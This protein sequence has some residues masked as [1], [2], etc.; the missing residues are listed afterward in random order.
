MISLQEILLKIKAGSAHDFGLTGRGVRVAVI[1]SG[2]N[3]AHPL[4]DG[5][6]VD[7]F[8]VVDGKINDSFGHGTH[9]TSI[10]LAVA[11]DA[12]IFNIKALD[13]KGDSKP[14]LVMQALE[15]AA[16][17]GV[18][19]IN[20]SVS[21]E[22]SECLHP[23]NHT[24]EVLSNMGILVVVSAGNN[25][26]KTSPNIPSSSSGSI[27]VGS[28]NEKGGM[29]RFSSRGPSC[30]GDFP[31][32]VSFG[33]NVIAANTLGGVRSIS[34][35][36]Q[37]APQVAGMFALLKQLNRKIDRDL[38]EKILELSCTRISGRE[39]SNESGWGLINIQAALRVAQNLN[40][41]PF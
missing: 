20:L 17:L 29:S 24:V 18:D 15:I 9:V 10:L 37:A 16:S 6:V 38:A 21:E 27:S 23:L 40:N 30:G 35:T 5:R 33:A 2:I 26:P 7:N 36:S 32:C 14:S 34:G 3:N 12:R 31:D 8:Q 19:V 1:D 11:P 13:D 39:K 28:V 25:G 4:I 41:N 22:S